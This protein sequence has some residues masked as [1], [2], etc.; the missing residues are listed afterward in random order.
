MLALANKKRECAEMLLTECNFDRSDVDINGYSA[1]H[2]AARKGLWGMV[3]ALI[4]CNALPNLQDK[5]RILI[6][7]PLLFKD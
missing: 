3:E 2:I 7:F 4:E 6:I 5:V 1:L